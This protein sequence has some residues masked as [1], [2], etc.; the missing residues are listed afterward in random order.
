MVK[1]R[2][3]AQEKAEEGKPIVAVVWYPEKHD[4][5][6]MRKLAVDRELLEDSYEDW[7][8][9]F[10]KSEK[11]LVAA[12]LF[13]V[14]TPIDVDEYKDWCRSGQK[15]FNASSRSQFAAFLLNRAHSS[16]D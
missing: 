5:D 11:E 8:R 13:P 6:A 2:R 9:M 15:D 7:I 14:R 12:G 3:K 4:W 1:I 10:E 16:G